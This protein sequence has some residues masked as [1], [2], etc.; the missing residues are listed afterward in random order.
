MPAITTLHA[1]TEALRSLIADS[2]LRVRMGREGRRMAEEE[3]NIQ[4]VNAATMEVYEKA[5][6]KK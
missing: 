1:L 6:R 5:L 4:R 2:D 3:F